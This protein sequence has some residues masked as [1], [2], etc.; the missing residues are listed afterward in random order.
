ME[1]LYGTQERG[2]GKENFRVSKISSIHGLKAV[3]KWG[4]GDKGVRER[5][6]RG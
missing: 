1:L 2:K 6:G 5:N 4:V 3:E